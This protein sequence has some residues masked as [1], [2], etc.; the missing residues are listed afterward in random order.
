[1]R[2]VVDTNVFVSGLISARGATARVVDAI[3]AGRIVPLFS[4]DTH[5][6]LVEVLDRPKLKRYLSK[7]GVVR[8]SFL[9]DLANIAEFVRA[10]PVQVQ[11]RD[12]KDRP[13]VAVA[14]SIPPPNFLITGDRDFEKLK[15]E[16]VRIVSPAW[17]VKNALAGINR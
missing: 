17:F 6:E 5:A 14:A 8:E 2:V 9:A 3:L 10:G 15:I 4:E 11:I 16:P 12:P 7:A 1:V 13:I